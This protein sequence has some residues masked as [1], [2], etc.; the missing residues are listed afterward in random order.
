MVKNILRAEG[1]VVFLASSYFYVQL[2]ANIILFLALWLLPDVS[3]V[4]YLKDKKMGAIFYDF[5][6]NYILSLGIIVLGFVLGNTFIV[7]LGLILSSHIGLDRFFGYGVKYASSF[8]DT[9]I[10]KLIEELTVK[11]GLRKEDVKIKKGSLSLPGF[12]RATKQWDMLVVH[13]GRLI[14]AF[15]F[16]SQAG[17]SFGNNFNNRSEEALGSATD[18]WQAVKEGVFGKDANPF[19]RLHDVP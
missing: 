1:L 17:P 12:F 11:N 9:H 7:S 13:K 10:Q 18:L 2:D 16:K 19:F 8:K 3:M 14:A 6:H 15:E 5:V 4:G